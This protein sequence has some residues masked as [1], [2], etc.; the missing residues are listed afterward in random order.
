MWFI[1]FWQALKSKCYAII[2]QWSNYNVL[3]ENYQAVLRLDENPRTDCSLLSDASECG[4]P[5]LSDTWESVMLTQIKVVLSQQFV[6]MS[7]C[8]SK[9]IKLWI[10]YIAA[11][12]H[13]VVIFLPSECECRLLL[14][15]PISASFPKF[16]LLPPCDVRI[17]ENNILLI[18]IERA[19]EDLNLHYSSQGRL[20]FLSQG[21]QQAC[22]IA[23]WMI[24][25]FPLLGR[26]SVLAFNSQDVWS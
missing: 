23:S 8:A 1:L 3:D 21:Y 18:Q 20:F 22:K 12:P 7:K 10:C 24:I 11:A 2:S 6:I 13:L 19:T 26:V 5:T 4:S 14:C 15:P 16:S 25:L 9:V 17:N